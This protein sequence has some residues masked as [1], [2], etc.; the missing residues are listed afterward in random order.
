MFY[1]TSQIIKLKGLGAFPH[2][3]P[4]SLNCTPKTKAAIFQQWVPLPW[5]SCLITWYG[6]SW[7]VSELCSV[8]CCH[9]HRH[10]RWQ[11]ERKLKTVES[12][13]WA[14]AYYRPI[15]T[16]NS[17]VGWD[18]LTLSFSS[19]IAG[20]QLHSLSERVQFCLFYNRRK[21]ARAVFWDKC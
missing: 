12:L 17:C 8:T 7:D 6:G 18:I 20:K 19:F 2:L 13:S 11:N 10:Y 1:F 15:T 9:G 16:I 14:K 3:Q 5:S 4:T 21:S